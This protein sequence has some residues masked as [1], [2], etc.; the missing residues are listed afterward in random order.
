MD[1]DN[2]AGGGGDEDDKR[3]EYHQKVKI[4]VEH[5]RDEKSCVHVLSSLL[6]T[7][8][9]DH[10]SQQLQHLDGQSTEWSLLDLVREGGPIQTA[11]AHMFKLLGTEMHSTNLGLLARH[12]AGK[13]LCDDAVN[14]A[15]AAI[16]FISALIWAKLESVFSAFPWILVRLGDPKWSLD[17]K[18][19]LAEICLPRC[20]ATLMNRFHCAYGDFCLDPTSCW[21]CRTCSHPSGNTPA[22]ATCHLRTCLL[23]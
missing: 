18:Q 8:P 19:A 4:A 12:F 15:R 23:C 10:L 2:A 13:A 3:V 11:Q 9:A 17:K 21:S 16:V 22:L 14:E 1:V 20:C 6:V 7:E 5:L